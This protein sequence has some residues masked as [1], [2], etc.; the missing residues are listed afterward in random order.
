MLSTI[1]E[2]YQPKKD[3]ICLVT[4]KMAMWR[5]DLTMIVF[6]YSNAILLRIIITIRIA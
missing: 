3:V 6:I 5:W 1:E 2:K 4:L